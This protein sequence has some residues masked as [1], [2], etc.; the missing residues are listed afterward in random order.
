M[1]SLETM[2]YYSAAP[3]SQQ[4]PPLFRW[5]YPNRGNFIGF[6]AN[7]K[8]R[9]LLR[10]AAAGFRGA[11]DFPVECCATWSGVPGVGWSDH[12]SFWAQGYPAVMVTDTAPYRYPHYHLASDTPDRL[13]YGKLARVVDGLAAALRRLCLLAPR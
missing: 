6:V 8:S 13:D 3:G 9:G 12:A 10:R 4:Y 2:G 7:L 11:T 1:L 5:F